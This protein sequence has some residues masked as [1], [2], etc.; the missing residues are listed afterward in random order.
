MR[1]AYPEALSRRA[2]GAGERV[3][4]TRP[5]ACRNCF[6]TSAGFCLSMSTAAFICCIASSSAAR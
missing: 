4:Y 3:G 6:A 2:D 1:R 5:F